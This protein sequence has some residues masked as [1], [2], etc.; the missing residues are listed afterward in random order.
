MTMTD[1]MREALVKQA[2]SIAGDGPNIAY[3]SRASS[4]RAREVVRGLLKELKELQFKYDCERD[5][6]SVFQQREAALTA[7]AQADIHANWKDT[8]LQ[9]SWPSIIAV[10]KDNAA[11][12]S[13]IVED[14][15]TIAGWK[16]NGALLGIKAVAQQANYSL[17]NVAANLEAHPPMRVDEKP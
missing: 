17:M 3:I 6:T 5:L 16:D 2:E 1:A 15:E 12:C 14:V 7:P 4:E 11:R 13:D 8:M 10:V 9:L